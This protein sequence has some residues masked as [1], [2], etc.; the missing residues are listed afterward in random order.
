MTGST[1]EDRADAFAARWFKSET[2]ARCDIGCW[3]IA[4]LSHETIEAEKARS[5]AVSPGG[6]PKSS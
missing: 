3:E 1:P 6:A 2:P 5:I 4:M